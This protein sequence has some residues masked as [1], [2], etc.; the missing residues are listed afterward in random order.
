MCDVDFGRFEENPWLLGGLDQLGLA[1]DVPTMLAH[2][3]QMLYHWLTSD[4]A[5]GRGD[6]VEL[7]SFVGGSTA[8]LAEG[9]RK[10]GLATKIHAYDRFGSSEGL[11]QSML[12]PAG[13]APFEGEDIL[14]VAQD[15]LS[16]WAPNVVFHK[17][18]IETL[19]WTGDAIEILVMDASKSPHAM[20]DMARKFFPSLV[21]DGLVVQQDYLH[22][23][24]PWVAVQ[25][26]R[27]RDW[28][29]P[30]AMALEETLVFRVL[31]PIDAEALAAGATEHLSDAELIE[32]LEEARATYAM[33]GSETHL[34]AAIAG[35]K[36]SP[37]VRKAWQMVAK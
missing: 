7:G 23:R 22:W 18:E 17:G 30:V 14:P 6:I 12:Y 19:D 29:E 27:M 2:E 25:M 36:R 13:I 26:Q 28:F 4:W 8:R 3:E 10:A 37:G 35:V 15:L 34:D 11:K 20:D 5:T 33:F 32:G 16:P 9:H 21:V 31:K 1:R 24:Q